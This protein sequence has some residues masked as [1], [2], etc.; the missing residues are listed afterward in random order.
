MSINSII[1]ILDTLF[2]GLKRPIPLS[3]PFLGLEECKAVTQCVE[4]GWVSYL[5]P[6]VDEFESALADHLGGGHVIATVS[7]TAALHLALILAGVQQGDEVLIPAFTFAATANAVKFAG[8]EP[9]FVD[10][11][12]QTLGICPKRLSDHLYSSTEKVNG[13]RRNKATGRRITALV[14]VHIFGHPAMTDELAKVCK[15]FDIALVEDAAESLGSLRNGIPTGKK[16]ITAAISFNGNKIVTAGG[17]GAVICTNPEIAVIGRHLSTTAKVAHP[18]KLSHDS[19]GFNYRMPNLNAALALAQLNRIDELLV[20]KRA[21]AKRYAELF[22]G[23]NGAYFLKEPRGTRSN[24]WLN[25]IILEDAMLPFR[26]NL[27]Q[28]IRKAGF[29]IRPAW[30]LLNTLPHFA[31]CP[32]ADLSVSKDMQPRIVNL[33]SS[34]GLALLW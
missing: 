33:P 27:F 28:E 12:S 32:C 9:H 20:H 19:I 26:D 1:N 30:E 10:I 22:E 3:E 17:G 15:E 16:G 23:F 2:T 4:S 29:L 25:T 14:P 13:Q 6:E 31:G 24:Y 11:E 7:G 8:A 18:W 34:A 21:L 5:G